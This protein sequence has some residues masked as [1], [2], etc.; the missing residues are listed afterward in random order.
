MIYFCPQCMREMAA[1]ARVCPACG[2]EIKDWEH[3]DFD[4]KLINAIHHWDTFTRQRAVYL[5]GERRTRKAFRS[6]YEA[7]QMAQ[8]PYL[9]AEILRSLFKIN[10][11]KTFKL[12]ARKPLKKE[13]IIVQ[14]VFAE[15]QSDHER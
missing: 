14:T 3:F 4:E 12:F 8:D 6:L 15:Y 13:S 5:L 9:K 2:F 1:Q 11:Q 7:F 10:R